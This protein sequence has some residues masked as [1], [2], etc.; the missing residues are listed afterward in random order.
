MDAHGEAVLGGL[1]IGVLISAI[2]PP[3]SVI[4]ASRHSSADHY[5]GARRE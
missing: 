1:V 5:A 2:S 3:H 4:A